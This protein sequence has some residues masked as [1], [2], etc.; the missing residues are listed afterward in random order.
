M[1]KPSPNVISP[2][3]FAIFISLWGSPMTLLTAGAL[4]GPRLPATASNACTTDARWGSVGE[5][6]NGKT[7]PYSRRQMF[8]FCLSSRGLLASQL[9][10]SLKRE[11]GN[12]ARN[13]GTPFR[14]PPSKIR[15]LPLQNFSTPYLASDS[16]HAHF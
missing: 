7:S 12:Q 13:Q 6:Y 2:I 11:H 3:F 1:Q 14:E 9:T 16:N 15:P 4:P 10:T 5:C 8:L